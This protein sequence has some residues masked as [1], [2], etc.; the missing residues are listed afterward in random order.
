MNQMTLSRKERKFLLDGDE[1]RQF[2]K[3]LKKYI[4]AHSFIKGKVL[5]L[6]STVYFDTNN[7]S[8]FNQSIKDPTQNTKI[9]AREYYYYNHELIEHA[10][11]LDEL[12]EHKQDIFLEIKAKNQNITSKKRLMIPRVLLQTAKKEHMSNEHFLNELKKVNPEFE[13]KPFSTV[14]KQ[15]AYD[16]IRPVA[17]VHY[18]RNAYEN[19]EMGLRI[20]LDQEMSFHKMNQTEF[21]GDFSWRKDH[22]P[23]SIYDETKVI[24]EV[25][26]LKEWPK[27]LNE[28]I[29]DSQPQQYSKFTECMKKVTGTNKD[30]EVNS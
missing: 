4:N 11:N 13:D 22:L 16:E 20:S 8:L 28:L 19:E 15:F 6:V 27:W 24:L 30:V 10:L 1:A 26:S 14:I 3:K 23:D 17:V 9:R 25:K 18:A 21:E 29:G 7:L 5:T 12:Y 2:K